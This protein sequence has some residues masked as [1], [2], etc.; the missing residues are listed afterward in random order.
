MQHLKH[1]RCEKGDRV[2][3]TGDRRHE[4]GNVDQR[5]WDRRHKKG[6]RRYGTVDLGPEM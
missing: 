6:D 2:R 3:E 4:A 5:V 1:G